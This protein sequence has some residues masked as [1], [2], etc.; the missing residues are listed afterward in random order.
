MSYNKNEVQD[1]SLMGFNLI[2]IPI[3]IFKNLMDIPLLFGEFR[4]IREIS[5]RRIQQVPQAIYQQERLTIDFF[6]KKIR[7]LF[8]KSTIKN[9]NI[10]IGILNKKLE[11]II[12]ELNRLKT[13]YQ[14]NQ[15]NPE[16]QKKLIFLYRQLRIKFEEALRK[17][18]E[19]R[20]NPT[21]LQKF[22]SNT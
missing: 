7:D 9:L 18:D 1:F 16:L 5:D 22:L 19:V 10:N 11:P 13:T 14:N 21:A 17:S 3:Q 6:E 4:R 20:K 2:S 12:K 15:Q 8:M